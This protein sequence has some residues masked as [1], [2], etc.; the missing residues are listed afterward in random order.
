VKSN[1]HWTRIGG[2]TSDERGIAAVPITADAEHGEFLQQAADARHGLDVE[3]AG[4]GP[5]ILP[6]EPGHEDPSTPQEAR[7]TLGAG[8]EVVVRSETGDGLAGIHVRLSAAAQALTRKPTADLP[9]TMSFTS[10]RWTD[11]VTG[12]RKVRSGL[13]RDLEWTK[14]TDAAGRAL[15]EDLPGNVP[16]EELVYKD[17]ELLWSHPCTIRLQAGDHRVVELTF[18]ELSDVTGTL[19]DPFDA[20]VADKW[21]YLDWAKDDAVGKYL[22]GPLSWID[23]AKTDATGRFT[24]R[25]IAP[26]V[27]FAGPMAAGDVSRN[28]IAP[29]AERIDVPQSRAKGSWI[30]RTH[31]GLFIRGTVVGP[32][33]APLEGAR[34]RAR[35]KAGFG[36]I[37]SNS[38]SEGRFVLGP[39]FPEVFLV[40]AT[41]GALS[42]RK[43]LRVEASSGTE[44]LLLRLE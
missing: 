35:S 30:L 16:L 29:R 11:R 22:F 41:Q 42:L 5:A 10:T 3:A 39:L 20:P 19:L 4:F 43:E 13:S 7:L 14:T 38:D 32:N 28:A 24:F 31:R 15:F 21:I 36:L 6:I 37:V 27:Y 12:E 8:L 2:A 18:G 9:P 23:R 44:D 17:R 34:I 33:G 26:G 25:G 1:E 40:D